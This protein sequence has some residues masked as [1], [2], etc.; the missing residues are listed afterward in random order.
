[1][2]RQTE[3]AWMEEAEEIFDQLQ[4]E[5]DIVQKMANVM[6]W[7][8]FLGNWMTRR[9]VKNRF[10]QINKQLRT[11]IFKYMIDFSFIK[12]VPSKSVG[13]FPKKKTQVTTDDKE[14][15]DLLDE[16]HRQLNLEQ[17]MV[18][19][20]LKQFLDDFKQVHRLLKD[21]KAVEGLNNSR[22]ASKDQIKIIVKDAI[23]SLSS[24]QPQRCNTSTQKEIDP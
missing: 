5:I 18:S 15:L 17:S 3:K 19:S 21:A 24:S 1:M 7:L 11:L 22:M 9:R 10:G 4:H 2:E 6:R 20:R 16:F 12:R 14:I 13:L 8:P 23:S